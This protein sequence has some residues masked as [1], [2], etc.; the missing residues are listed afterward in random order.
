LPFKCTIIRDVIARN[1]IGVKH[2]NVMHYSRS[3]GY[4]PLNL[5]EMQDEK[6]K[7]CDH[8][9]RQ[10]HFLITDGFVEIGMV[11]K[12]KRCI[13]LRLY[14]SHLKTLSKI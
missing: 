13:M 5:E 14:M 6:T 11:M 7:M 1:K 9:L 3:N 8:F 10:I 2:F 12:N 4:L